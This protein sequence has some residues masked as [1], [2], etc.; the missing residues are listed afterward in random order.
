MRPQAST[1]GLNLL[2]ISVPQMKTSTL[3]G[4]I[5]PTQLPP[6]CYGLKDSIPHKLDWQVFL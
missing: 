5:P 3:K 1:M 6:Y 2:N 4:A